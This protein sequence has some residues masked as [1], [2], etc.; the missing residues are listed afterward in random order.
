[1]AATLSPHWLPQLPQGLISANKNVVAMWWQCSSN[2][3]ATWHRRHV[4]V[5][6]FSRRRHVVVV[7]L[8][9][10]RHF[11]AMLLSLRR[12]VVTMPGHVVVL[13]W[14]LRRCLQSVGA[15]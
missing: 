4:A 15:H 1:M 8:R 11:V 7:W 13:V 9:C 10:R 3:P 6:S 5:M 2:V 12:H 14:L